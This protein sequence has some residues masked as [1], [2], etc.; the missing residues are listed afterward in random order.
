LG[1]A[2]RGGIAGMAKELFRRDIALAR[3]AR[4]FNA[5]VLTAVGG[6]FAAHAGTLLRR[7][8]VIFYDTAEAVLQNLVTYPFAS[9]V[10]VPD[11]YDGWT[12]RRRTVR[13]R[14]YHELAYLHPN[15][16]TP[17]RNI[18]LAAGLN[19]Q[20]P[21]F[22]V[23]TVGWQA[24]HDLGLKGWSGSFLKQ[25]VAHL[26]ESGRVVISSEGPLPTEL[27]AL[28]FRSA[29][30]ALHHLMAHCDLYVGESAT[31]ASESAVLGVPALYI[32]PSP[33]CYTTD[34]EDRYGLIHCINV[35]NFDD[36][37]PGIYEVLNQDR[38]GLDSS[39]RQMFANADD[40]V[41][42]T[43]QQLLGVPE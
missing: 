39:R 26:G 7:R 21:T 22:L 8:S 35:A 17:D 43:S 1:V 6:T 24:S 11:C 31:M 3:F 33:R 15:V 9:R 19:P 4:H 12:P 23:R 14:G 27:E 42:M 18:A 13:Y 37:R 41:A 5:D 20:G 38:A 2:H 28:R 40:V 29:A 36:I 34:I 16:F 30:S 32:A 25:L 10:V